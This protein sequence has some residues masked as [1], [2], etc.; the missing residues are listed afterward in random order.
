M[1]AVRVRSIPATSWAR[2]WVLL[3]ASIVCF[4]VTLLAKGDQVPGPV[5]SPGADGAAMVNLNP[6]FAVAGGAVTF[7]ALV[8]VPFQDARPED[9]PA[10][11]GSAVANAGRIVHDMSRAGMAQRWRVM[12][13]PAQ[14]PQP[15][16]TDCCPSRSPAWR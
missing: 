15:T 2:R 4:V 10:E 7:P 9:G 6:R 14:I 16:Q 3:R 11:T 1:T 5:I 12:V 8:T 13:I